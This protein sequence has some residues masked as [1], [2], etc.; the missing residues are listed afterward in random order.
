MNQK[1]VAYIPLDDR[2][3]NYDRVKLAAEAMGINLL[4]P[5]VE[6]FKN[7]LD[8]QGTND[9]GWQIGCPDKIEQWFKQV[10]QQYNIDSYIISLDQLCSGGLIGA[11]KFNHP[12]SSDEALNRVKRVMDMT[13]GKKVYLFDVVL[14]LA[15]TVGFD[16]LTQADYEASWNYASVPRYKVD[17]GMYNENEERSEI[18]GSYDMGVD[19]KK[20]D[21]SKYGFAKVN[22][23]LDARM[24]KFNLN[25][26]VGKLL[27]NNYP[28]VD[29]VYGVGDANNNNTIQ[30]NEINHI[31]KYIIDA[32]SQI[33]AGIDELGMTML[34][35]VACDFYTTKRI[36]VRTTYFGPG[37]DK[38]ADMYDYETLR[39]N[40]N[41]HIFLL[42]NC[43]IVSGNETEDVEVLILT[44][45]DDYPNLSESDR[46]AAQERDMYQF[47]ND[48][49]W[50]INWNTR[51]RN[52]PTI[53]IDASWF[54]SRGGIM[55]SRLLGNYGK[56]MELPKIL[57][58][59][60]WNTVGNAVGMALG[61]GIGRYAYLKSS[62]KVDRRKALTGQVKILFTEY[63]KDICYQVGGQWK[64]DRD[65]GAGASNFAAANI[66]MNSEWFR[67]TASQGMLDDT[68]SIFKLAELFYK[69]GYI[70]ED[71]SNYKLTQI[72]W[73]NFPYED[74]LDFFPIQ[75]PWKRTFE[76]T[77]PVQVSFK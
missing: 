38:L 30:T 12:I 42:G 32:S 54:K 75:F 76:C 52:H 27:S 1:I 60:N 28:N 64:L 70:Y 71:L 31:K 7:Y 49:H 25:C 66:D 22:E 19:G 10:N 47:S 34:G 11:R 9:R 68:F 18:I 63:A 74:G 40:V 53:V 2:P 14:R 62:N 4:T 35:R 45:P 65:F 67:K 15:T 23:Y 56:P 13:N 72:N 61:H 39:Q 58:Y 69:D 3:C 26:E 29:F 36:K 5:P 6:Y 16:G 59:S 44:K 8:N 57:A 41:K 50:H 37:A 33:F 21:A 43:E 77:F 46:K 55:Q 51:E 17:I 24:R 20:I 73:V 48:I